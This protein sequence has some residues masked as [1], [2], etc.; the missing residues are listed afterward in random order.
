MSEI[1]A[2]RNL[3]HHYS[4]RV[5]QG[6][7][8]GWLDLWTSDGVWEIGRGPVEGLDAL[9]E[10]IHKSMSL[11]ES[12]NQMIFNGTAQTNGDEGNGRWYICEFAKAKSSKA[13]FY[14]GHYDDTYKKIEGNWKFSSRQL[15]WLYQGAPDLS[16]VFGPPPGYN[17]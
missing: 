13:V 4:D 1:E 14:L 16:G 6:D 12:V 9:Q 7:Q 11:F 17:T 3:V 5:C 8:E 10:A 2:I 15:S